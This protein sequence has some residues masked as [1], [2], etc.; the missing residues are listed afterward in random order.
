MDGCS[1]DQVHRDMMYRFDQCRLIA[2]RLAK[3]ATHQLAAAVV[4][5]I[6]NDELRVTVFNPLPRSF[7]GVTE[8]TLQIP[9]DW[10]TFNEFFGYE[11]KPAFRVYGPDGTEIPY[12]RLGQAMSQIK[13]RVRPTKFVESYRTHDVTVALPLAIPAMGYATLTVRSGHPGGPTRYPETPGLATS[14]CTMANEFLAVEIATN[15]TLTLTDKRTGQVYRRLLTFEDRADLGDGWYHGLAVNDQVFVS[16]ACRADVALVHDG[17]YLTTFRI[18]TTMAVPEAFRFDRA[19]PELAEGMARS[20]RMAELVLDSLVSL[21]PGQDYLDVRTTVHNAADDHRL[22]VLFPTGATGA[23]TCLAD[24]PFDVVER[25]IALRPDNHLYRELEVET[26]P[27]QSWTAV[28][29]G[30]H[31]LAVVA[32]GLLETAVR[33]L[34]E[35]LLALTLFRGTRRT[36]FTEGEPAGQVRGRLE[37]AYRVAPLATEPDRARLCE[38]GQ[39]LSA[40]L[41]A[42]QLRPADLPLYREVR[43]SPVTLGGFATTNA[44]PPIASFLR[45]EGPAVLTSACQVGDGLEVRLFNPWPRPIEVTLHPWPSLGFQAVQRVDFESRGLEAPREIEDEITVALGEKEILTLRFV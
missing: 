6:A 4:G 35:R 43:R 40:G 18:R 17:R 20:E 25:P 32:D 26:R 30:Q 7:D 13:H 37:F 33:D 8:L 38:M 3:E 9:S 10:P 1:I 42:V 5:E 16:T 27:Q 45:L 15:G 31:G 11:P 24:S 39:Q 21:R 36:I 14:E 19:C 44:L 41:R 29:D 2:D 23:T 12:Q 34:P 28:C 22:R